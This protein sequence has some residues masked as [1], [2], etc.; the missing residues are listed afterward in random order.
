MRK[1]PTEAIHRLKAF[2]KDL[3]VEGSVSRGDIFALIIEYHVA[4]EEYEAAVDTLVEMKQS[5]PHKPGHF[6]K[7][8]TLEVGNAQ[9][10]LNFDL[11]FYETVSL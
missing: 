5:I 11:H 9:G 10:N 1:N 3:N 7:K 4:H 8:E 6:I 2:V